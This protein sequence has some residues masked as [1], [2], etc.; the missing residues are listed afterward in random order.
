MNRQINPNR[1]SFWICWTIICLGLGYAWASH[2]Y[3]KRIRVQES[4][5]NWY[6]TNQIPEAYQSKSSP[7][8]KVMNKAMMPKD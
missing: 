3:L 4:L 5:I 2:A 6:Q 7:A 1:I 8:D